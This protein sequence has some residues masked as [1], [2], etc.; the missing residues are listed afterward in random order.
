MD[1]MT[2][3]RYYGLRFP[4]EFLIRDA[5]QYAGL[6]DCQARDEQK[7]ITILILPCQWSQLPKLLITLSIPIEQK[8]SFSMADIKMLYMTS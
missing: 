4:V 7:F 6:E 2:L 5:K 3:C 1:A 8:G